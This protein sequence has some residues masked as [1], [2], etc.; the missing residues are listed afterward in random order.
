[1]S[2][3]RTIQ[4]EYPAKRG[5]ITMWSPVSIPSTAQA[6]A[7]HHTTDLLGNARDLNLL[8]GEDF[9]L[10]GNALIIRSS[11]LLAYVIPSNLP[12]QWV[13]Y[14]TQRIVE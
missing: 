1:M 3:A 4:Y 12:G 14:L 11:V 10:N 7:I 6:S 2:P 5:T 8:N 13:A 9:N